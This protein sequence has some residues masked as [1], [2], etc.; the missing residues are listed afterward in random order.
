MR[1]RF[2][3]RPVTYLSQFTLFVFLFTCALSSQATQLVR[4]PSLSGDKLTFA[5]A[6]DIWIT[7]VNGGDAKRLTSFQGSESMPMLSPNGQYVAFTGEYAGNTD[8]YLVS[9]DGGPVRRLTYHPGSDVS[10]AWAPDSQS[11]L[12]RSTRSNAP[13]GWD[14]LYQVG[15]DEATPERLPM[16][17]AFSGSF[18]PDASKLVFRRAGFW[19]RGWRNYRGGQNQALRIIDLDSLEEQDLPFDNDFDLDPIW[20]EEYIYF[21]SNRSQVANVFRYNAATAA[22]EQVTHSTDFDVMSFAV[23]KGTL[24]YEYMGDFYR[25]QVPGTAT[26]TSPEKITINIDTNFYWLR[27]QYVDASKTLGTFDISPNAKRAVFAGRGDIFT[28]PVEHGSVRN[29][30]D[31]SGTREVSP[32]WSSDGSK[33][34]WFSDASGEYRLVIADQHGKQEKEIQLK[35]EGFY[36]HLQWS[37]DDS[38][39]MFTDNVQQLWIVNIDNE[40]S[41]VID[42]NT[43]VHVMPQLM[44]SWS[45]DSKWIAYTTQN[46]NM[47]REL[48]IYSV[49]DREIVKVTDG[50][51]EMRYPVWDAQGDKLYFLASTDYG[52]NAAWLDM[53]TIPFEPTYHLY[54]MLL[55]KDGESP[56]LA[57]S[58]EEALEE[59]SDGEA[60]SEEDSD[61]EKPVEVSIDFDGLS[62]RVMPLMAHS[63]HFSHLKSGKAGELFYLSSYSDADGKTQNDLMKYSP[64]ERKVEKVADSVSRYKL[65][66]NKES[67]LLNTDKGWHVFASSASSGKDDKHLKMTLQKRVNY[68]QEWQQIFR[69]AWRFQRDYLYVDNFHG[70][71][72]DAVYTAYQPLVA[73]VSHPADLSYLLDTLGAEVSIGHSYTGSG[74]QPKV[75]ANK[76]GLLG[77][78]FT[79]TDEGVQLAKIYTGES[80]FPSQN[81][82][83][84]LAKVA[85]KIAP[86]SYL[87]SVNGQAVDAS[88]NIFT[89][90]EGT[91]GQVTQITIGESPDD[92]EPQT[93]NVTPIANEVSLRR[94][95][96]VERNRAYVDQ[97]SDGKLAYVWIPNTAYD[98]FTS[99]NRYFFAQSHKQGVVLD[100]RF[101][102]GGLIADYLI[103]V[104]RRELNGF[105][106]NPFK[107]DQPMT[108]PGAGIWGAQ[109]MLINEVSGSGG[110]MLP[111]M[112][113]FYDMG[114]LV[115]KRTWGGLV[116]IWGVPPLVDGGGITAPRSGFYDI[117]GQWKVENEGVAPDIEVEQLTIETSKGRDPQLDRAIQEALKALEDYESPIRPQ[118]AAPVRVPQV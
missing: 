108:S 55:S 19:D 113:R 102:H 79:I 85:H 92:D 24:V 69:E 106:N 103:S 82:A 23:D 86:N 67:V 46:A 84:P 22:L 2:N 65:S 109:V 70:A 31:S 96:W 91:L 53:S 33:I 54:Y 1:K 39:V 61:E 50:M 18:S 77:A 52:P 40:S 48:S 99:F 118:P 66:F 62:Q 90:F 25:M 37:P 117:D 59:K 28:V 111:Y 60:G 41:R 105:F 57:R 87:L 7:S 34:A 112:F 5:Y 8:V 20:D 98:G 26:K 89:Y 114:K 101:N 72:W 75:D 78:D 16:N 116:G 4:Q 10:V 49:D 73:S 93:F 81:M 68:A 83:A 56:V 6:N 43:N 35:E 12:F 95:D 45:P 115:G 11:V 14:R 30:S 100:E 76:V 74:E 44:A 15:I 27:E 47:F 51:A 88:K 13:R 36:Q 97:A 80:Y 9:A 104:L 32:A 38:R 58:D 107:P 3:L 17:R 29:L 110:D 94:N 42:Q 71:N 63:G 21:L 64:H